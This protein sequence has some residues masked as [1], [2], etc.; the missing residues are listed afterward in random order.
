MNPAP[1]ET[2]TRQA[3]VRPVCEYCN[4]HRSAGNHAKCSLLRQAK[5]AQLKEARQ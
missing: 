2:T 1:S 3:G 4:R 5:F